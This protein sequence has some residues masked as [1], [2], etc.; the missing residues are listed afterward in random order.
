MSQVVLTK[1]DINVLE[2][3]KDPEASASCQSLIDPSLPRD[4]HLQDPAIYER[5]ASRERAC[6]LSMQQLEIQL[7][8]QRDVVEGY[9]DCIKTLDVLVEEY[10]N[11]AS[12]RNNR[13][14]ALRRVYGDN[15]LVDEGLE[16][17]VGVAAAKILNDLDKAVSL[18]TPSTSSAAVSPQA[19]KTLAQAFTQRGA[20]YHSTSK[21]LITRSS[22]KARNL[23]RRHEMGWDGNMF[24]EA[25]SNDFLMGGR[26]GNEIAKALAVHTNP[27]AKLCGEMVREAMKE[28]GL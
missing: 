13:A 7:S 16:D 12:A 5:V 11:Y 22:C 1:N 28:Y 27:T 20:I 9:K 17:D 4:P 18:L 24:E 14:Q 10:P 8:N 23:G 2:K 26:Y 15:L 21:A 19:A 25:A 6:I 3:I